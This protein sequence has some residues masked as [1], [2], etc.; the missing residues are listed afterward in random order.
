MSIRKPHFAHLALTTIAICGGCLSGCATVTTGSD[1]SITI[2][3]VPDG[4]KCLMTRDG[5]TIGAISS[6]P[7]SVLVNKDKDPITIECSLAGHQ[8]ATESVDSKFQGATLGNVLIGGVIGIAIDAGSGA[9]NK[10]PGAI[11]IVLVP[12][13]FT[14]TEERDTFFDDV[15][16]R[17]QQQQAQL[18]QVEH[19]CGQNEQL[20]ND[21][22]T[23]VE[24]ATQARLEKLEAQRAASIV[25]AAATDAAAEPLEIAPAP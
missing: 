17:W 6:T 23:D 10:Y 3:S 14:S 15:R 9:M 21:M 5:E 25:V 24:K 22:R 16:T 13:R 2:T 18:A 7:G 11:E 1:Q 20:C 19:D 12:E 4:A 8:A